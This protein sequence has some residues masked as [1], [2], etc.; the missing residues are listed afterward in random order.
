MTFC[1]LN[2]FFS[3][4][5]ARLIAG[6]PGLAGRITSLPTEFPNE[7]TAFGRS[8][9]LLV[10]GKLQVPKGT[11]TEFPYYGQT[12]GFA[13]WDTSRTGCLVLVPP[14]PHLLRWAVVL[15]SNDDGDPL[16]IVCGALKL[17]TSKWCLQWIALS[18]KLK[19]AC[20]DPE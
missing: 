11:L 17:S 5:L 6:V 15:T 16:Q 3:P 7:V 9:A 8:M 13:Q 1:V 14:E 10:A 2:V 20:E 19:R 12:M 4:V 18:K